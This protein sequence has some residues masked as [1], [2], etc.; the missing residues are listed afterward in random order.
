MATASF[1]K[2]ARVWDVIT[3]SP[4]DAELLAE[5]AEGIASYQINEQ[6]LVEYIPD[7]AER[8]DKLREQ[9]ANATE[10]DDIGKLFVRWFLADRWTRTISPLSSVTV[11][12]YIRR[13]ITEGHIDELRRE[14]PGYP[15]PSQS[16]K[17]R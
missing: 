6:G 11:P 1:D 3:V 5:L 10:A 7:A 8:L 13:R 16:L 9:T 12:E 14:F 4:G 15:F 17:A 2:A